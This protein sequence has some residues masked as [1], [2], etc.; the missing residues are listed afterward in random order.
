MASGEFHDS[1]SHSGSF[2]SSGGGSSFSGGSSGGGGSYGSYDGDPGDGVVLFAYLA[3]A[4]IGGIITFLMKVAHN[5]I[6]G[7]NLINLAMFL[8]SSGFLIKSI[9]EYHRTKALAFFKEY[10]PGK[11]LTYVWKGDSVSK[12]ETDSK[13]WYGYN[14]CYFIAFYDLDFGDENAKKAYETMKSTPKIIWVS[15]TVWLVLSIICLVSTFFFYESIIPF[16]EHAI[17]TD[18]AFAFVDHLVFYF[19]AIL[20][21]LFA[22]G[23]FV[24]TKV[25]D[26][27]LYECAVRVVKDN[28]AA[29]EKLEKENAISAKLSNK[30]YYNI[31]PNCGAYPSQVLKHCDHCGASLEVDS[32]ENGTQSSVHKISLKE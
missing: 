23:S 6:P 29:A 18:F 12:I 31:C 16:F 27:F 4:V 28:K 24:L 8:V 3:A 17:M 22:V 10:G 21:L 30:W 19:P 14:K 2:H 25:K 32:F 7:L 13:S 26:N 1:G 20:C 15:P 9:S 11:N 5:E